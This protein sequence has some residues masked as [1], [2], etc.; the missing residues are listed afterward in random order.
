MALT[1]QACAIILLGVLALEPSSYILLTLLAGF[2]FG[3]NFVLFAKKTAVVFGV[4]QLGN[5]YPFVFLGYAF[6]GI[7]GPL[8]GG[9]LFDRF[10]NFTNAA[11]LA[12]LL[13]LTGGLLFLELYIR[14]RSRIRP[15]KQA[16][17]LPRSRI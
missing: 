8:S 16:R 17:D 3:A 1:L 2:G 6:A 12:A 14:T 10:G 5:I 9:L 11:A 7:F 15:G 4:E 13:S